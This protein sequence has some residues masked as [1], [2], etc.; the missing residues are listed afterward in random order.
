MTEGQTPKT[1][2]KLEGGGGGGMDIKFKVK[3]K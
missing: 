1:M 3:F 2:M